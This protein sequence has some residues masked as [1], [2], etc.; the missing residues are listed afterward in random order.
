MR[1]LIVSMLALAACVSSDDRPAD[2]PT[3]SATMF[4]PSCGTGGCHSQLSQVAGVILDTRV[5]GCRTLVSNPPDGYGPFVAAG[6]PE[7]SQLMFLLRGQEIRR[8]PPDGPLPDADLD[9]V[10]AWITAG[11]HCP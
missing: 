11:A 3:I 6:H 10:A 9:R 4:E 2:W 5:A 1:T 8:M 7:T